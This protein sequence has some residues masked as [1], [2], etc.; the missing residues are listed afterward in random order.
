MNT[1]P[2]GG[3]MLMVYL[4][5]AQTEQA[6]KSRVFPKAEKVM[7]ASSDGRESAWKNETHCFVNGYNPRGQGP[8]VCEWD[9]LCSINP[10][11]R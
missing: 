11:R 2:S 5:A 6:E 1:M 9:Y 3:L 7:H 8:E 10:G 4:S